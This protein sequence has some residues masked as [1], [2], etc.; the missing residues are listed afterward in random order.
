MD[1]LKGEESIGM[2]G[3][4][5]PFSPEQWLLFGRYLAI[6]NMVVWTFNLFFFLVPVFLPRAFRAYYETEFRGTESRAKDA[7]DPSKV[8]PSTDF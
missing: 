3:D 8:D 1:M 7:Q 4:T 5:G 2:N 6:G